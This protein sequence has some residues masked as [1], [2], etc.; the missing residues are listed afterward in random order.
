MS[1]SSKNDP[2]PIGAEGPSRKQL[3]DWAVGTLQEWFEG[4]TDAS[5]GTGFMQWKIEPTEYTDKGMKFKLAGGPGTPDPEGE[6]E[7]IIKLKRLP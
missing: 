6:Y 1:T 4:W 5:L 3:L 2:E 7:V